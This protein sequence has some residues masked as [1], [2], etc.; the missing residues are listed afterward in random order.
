L[1]SRAG[2]WEL[3]ASILV[4]LPSFNDTEVHQPTDEEA[5]MHAALFVLCAVCCNP[6]KSKHGSDLVL[7]D[8]SRW[9]WVTACTTITWDV[10]IGGDISIVCMVCKCWFRFY[11]PCVNSLVEAAR[12]IQRRRYQHRL[13]GMSVLVSLLPLLCVLPCVEGDDI[14]I[15][16]MVCQYFFRIYLLGV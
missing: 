15:D 2:D 3:R 10:S 8:R 5:L 9:A 14:S 13:H 11:L 12:C 4:V 6:S 7:G 1:K 16:C